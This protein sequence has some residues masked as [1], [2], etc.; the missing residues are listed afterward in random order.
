VDYL[1]TGEWELIDEYGMVYDDWEEELNGLVEWNGGEHEDG[2]F[3]PYDHVEKCGGG[4]HDKD[5]NVF[6]DVGFE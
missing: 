4:Y 3:V 1:K 5:G 2:D 6:L